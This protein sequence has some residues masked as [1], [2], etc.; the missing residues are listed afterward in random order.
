MEGD[1]YDKKSISLIGT[2]EEKSERPMS[3]TNTTG[4]HSIVQLDKNCL[5]C[6]AQSY[7]IISAFKMACLSYFPSNVKYHNLDFTRT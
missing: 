5:S 6:S 4:S 7:K 2:K 3:P 1:E